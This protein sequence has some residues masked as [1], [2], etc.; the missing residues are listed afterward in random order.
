MKLNSRG[1]G[2]R[3]VSDGTPYTLDGILRGIY[4]TRRV[5]ERWEGGGPARYDDY[6]PFSSPHYTAYPYVYLG[7]EDADSGRRRELVI[8]GQ[9]DWLLRLLGQRVGYVITIAHDAYRGQRVTSITLPV[10]EEERE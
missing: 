7:V 4:V 10:R 9:P 8:Q 1:D 5:I 2:I 3:R 6:D